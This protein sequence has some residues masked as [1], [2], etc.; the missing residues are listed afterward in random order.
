MP[1]LAI[2]IGGTKLQIVA[3]TATGEILDRRRFAVDRSAGGAAIRAQ[4]E[5]AL[6]ELLTKWSPSAIGCGYGGPV[7]WK[8]GRINRSHHVQGWEDFPL[9][10]WLRERT[11]LPA[12]VDNDANVAAYG[13]ALLGAGKGKNPVF[14]FNS[15]TGVGGGLVLDGRIYHGAPPGEI[16]FGHLRL[17]REGTIVEDR[18]SGRKVDEFLRTAAHRE[19]G[20]LL[21]QLIAGTPPGGEARHLPAALAKGCPLA[22]R[23]LNQIAGDLAFALG[24]VV[25]LLHPAAIV[26]GGGLSLIGEPLR[27]RIAQ[28]LPLH[29]MDAFTPGPPVFLAALGEDAV[30]VGALALAAAASIPHLPEEKPRA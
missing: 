12:A 30:P 26:F 13:E 19:P 3:G 29:V 17:D 6:P 11:G 20:A 27:A 5:G 4:I 1:F 8:T 10:E 21:S 7:D 28:Q 2:E 16:E 22:D 18:C 25:Q 23:I 14:Y 15:G 9:G 24:H